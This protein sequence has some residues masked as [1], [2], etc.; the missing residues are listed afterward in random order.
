MVTANNGSELVDVEKRV[1]DFQ[2]IKGPLDVPDA[3]RKGLPALL[4]FQS[5]SQTAVPVTLPRCQHVGM[6]VGPRLAASRLPSRQRKKEP[7]HRFPTTLG[8]RAWNLRVKCANDLAAYFLR[9]QKRL[10]RRGVAWVHSPCL[11]LQ[12]NASF[13]LVKPGTVSDQDHRAPL[14]ASVRLACSQSSSRSAAAS[15]SRGCLAASSICRKRSRKRRLQPR[16]AISASTPKWRLRFTTVNSRSPSS[17]STAGLRAGSSDAAS[18]SSSAVSSASLGSRSRQFGQSNPAFCALAPN[19]AASASAGIA[20]CT[21]SSLDEGPSC[22]PPLPLFS[23][24]LISSQFRN[25]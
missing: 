5:H 13:Q 25:T 17:A 19:F 14:W 7:N 1:L 23:A 2:R 21:P 16:S 22:A 12:L 10:A 20:R 24:V 8:P 18:A 11:H 3:A 15:S 4:E 6:Q 9:Q